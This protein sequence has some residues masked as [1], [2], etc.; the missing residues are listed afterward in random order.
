MTASLLLIDP[1]NDFCDIAG[2]ALP[3]AGADADLRRVAELM[4]LA[5]DRLDDVIVTLDSHASVGIERVTFWSTGAGEPVE[6]FTQITAA[7]V[8]AARFQPRDATRTTAVIGYLDA[9]ERGGRYRL[10]VWPVHCVVGTWGHNIHERVSAQIV[11]WENEQQRPVFRVLKGMNSMT[12]Q[13]SAVQAEVPI[14]DDPATRRNHALIERARPAAD[15]LLLVAGEASSHCVAATLEHL[16]AEFTPAE[17][18]RVRLLRDCMSPVRS[19]ESQAAAFF[20]TAQGQGA[21]AV[22]ALA[23]LAE[24][25]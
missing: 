16:L 17:C 13:Y 20:E 21:R 23:A 22:A 15:G 4:R 18:A 1:Q 10:V 5:G 6:P 14:A 9:L 12:E 7:D 3:V 25:G 24:L 11:R 19:F 8:R 2:A